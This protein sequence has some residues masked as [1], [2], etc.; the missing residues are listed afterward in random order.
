MLVVVDGG[1]VGEE[2]VGSRDAGDGGLDAADG[3]GDGAELEG[4][5]AGGGQERGE[6]HVVPGRHAHHVVQARVHPLHEPAPGP[7]GP[8]HHDPRLLPR[9][10]RPQPRRRTCIASRRGAGGG[11]VEGVEEGRGAR[12]GDAAGG[13]GGEGAEPEH[14]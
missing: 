1:A 12:G 10:R 9:P 3:L 2:E 8:Q 13:A 11:E 6:H 7:P 14:G 4:A 5:D